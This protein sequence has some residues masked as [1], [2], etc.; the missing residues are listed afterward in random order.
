MGDPSLL[1]GLGS[2]GGLLLE[3][4][5]LGLAGG[6]GF[7]GGL[8]GGLGFG[9]AVG[10]FLLGLG[11]GFEGLV[12]GFEVGLG[13]GDGLFGG[14][15]F[16]PGF[17][18]G[19]LGGGLLGGGVDVGGGLGFGV[20]LGQGVGE[21]LDL[22]GL[23]AFLLLRGGECGL[24]RGGCVAGLVAGFA[25]LL[26]FVGAGDVVG[27]GNLAAGFLRGLGLGGFESLLGGLAGLGD[28]FEVGGGLVGLGVGGGLLRGGLEVLDL[29]IHAGEAGSE[30]RGV[31][32]QF[33]DALGVR[34]VPDSDRAGVIAGDD[35]GAVVVEGGAEGEIGE[36]LEGLEGVAV[37]GP[38]F[39]LAVAARGDDPAVVGEGDGEDA[40]GVGGDVFGHLAVFHV[41]EL[42]GAVLG[43][44]R[45]EFGVAAEGGVG[46]ALLV[47]G[48]VVQFAGGVAL[49][50]PEAACAVAGG[51]IAAVGA[52]GDGLDPVGVLLDGVFLGGVGGG[53]DLEDLERGAQGD[54]GL[55]RGNVGGEDFVEFFADL[56]DALAGEH[57]PGDDLSGLGADAAAGDEELAVAGELERAREAFGEGEDADEFEGVGVVEEDL[58]LAADGDERGPGAG[59]DGGGCGVA[60]VGD[61]GLGKEFGVGRGH[62]GRALRLADAGDD[63]E[64]GLRLGGGDLG[65]G[66]LGR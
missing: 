57:V 27:G 22:L 16:G 31:G 30:G 24:C 39:D 46:D 11:L 62:G 7:G 20:G 8:G 54:A 29:L 34:E 36:L 66:G 50:D 14:G 21:L 37:G 5:A 48:A 60:V 10:G 1:R 13:L 56:G 45:E 53:V 41:P 52:E 12:G 44:R 43:G 58:F 40:A 47:A 51:E 26:H 38:D 19:G 61:D 33:A 4:G 25:L 28:G 17:G 49:P 59:G 32:G 9:E 63:G 55:V 35:A 65:G 18:G 3:L 23:G 64:V 42:D 2:G 15:V 6:E